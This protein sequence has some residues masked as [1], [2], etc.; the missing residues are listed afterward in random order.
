MSSSGVSRFA[1]VDT[2]RFVAAALVV[3]QHI[4]E[5]HDGGAIAKALVGL[6]PGVAGVVLFFL[7]SGYVI[8]FSVRSGFDPPAFLV[9]RLCRI[10]P[11]FLVAIACLAGVGAMGWLPQWAFMATAPAN[12][13]LANLLLVQDFV[14][15]EAF[16]GVSWTLII[17]L[18]WYALFAG[19]LLMLGSRAGRWLS[20][21]VPVGL[22]ALAALSLIIDIRIPLG[23][24]SMIY[25]AVLGYQ[26]FLYHTRAL[27]ARGLAANIAA[28]L[29]V[30][31][32]ANLVAFGV[33]AHPHIT[34]AQALGPWTVA[35]LL[36]FL[37]VLPVPI[38]EAGAINGGVLPALGA[39]SYSTYLLHPIANAVAERYIALHWEVPAALLLTL[40]LS[41][42]GYKF[43]EQPGI[44]LGR[45]LA[46]AITP[47]RGGLTPA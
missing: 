36:F 17:E 7:I 28:F 38:R 2:L 32:I 35:P 9:R 3:F 20:I 14:G 34:L 12:Q 37:V 25:A 24:P 6:G 5:R 11:L 10:Y 26:A 42:I 33:F 30:T 43:V 19:A 45:K 27:S 16:L 15:I 4:A 22:L 13:W 40:L 39:I 46:R 31:W 1:Y 47:L 29:V 8:P 44:A 18:I 41:A 23:R 21:A